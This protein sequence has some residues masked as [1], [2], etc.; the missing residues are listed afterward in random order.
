MSNITWCHTAGG[1]EA[2]D[3]EERHAIYDHAAAGLM[4]RLGTFL[5]R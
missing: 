1:H 4:C 5:V 2:G 3:L